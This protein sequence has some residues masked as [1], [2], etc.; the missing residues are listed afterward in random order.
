[1]KLSILLGMYQFIYEPSLAASMELIYQKIE[2]NESNKI[3]DI[4]VV[5]H[6]SNEFYR[7]DNIHHCKCHL[8]SKHIRT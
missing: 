5:K 6:I 4:F 1:M 2:I 8:K 7:F 3:K